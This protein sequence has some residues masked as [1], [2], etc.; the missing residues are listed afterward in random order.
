M[1]HAVTTVGFLKGD[2]DGERGSLPNTFWVI[3]HDNWAS[4]P[5]NLAIPWENINGIV[6][7]GGEPLFELLR[8]IQ[9]KAEG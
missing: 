4:T 6:F 9:H 7:F 5:Q 3:V 8:D 1:G 2:P